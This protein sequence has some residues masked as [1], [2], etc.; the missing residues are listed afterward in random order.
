MALKNVINAEDAGADNVD[1]YTR[2][3][4]IFDLI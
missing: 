3:S 1:D 4:F 2:I